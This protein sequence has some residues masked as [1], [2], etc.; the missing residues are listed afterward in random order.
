MYFSGYESGYSFD[1]IVNSGISEIYNEDQI[2]YII[3]NGDGASW[4]SAETENNIQKLYQL[5]LFH[6]YQKANRKI[7]NEESRKK[8]KKL[9]KK[10][11]YDK[12]L[13]LLKE[14]IES[15]KDVIL[16]A[17]PEGVEYRVLGTMESSIRNVIASRMKENGTA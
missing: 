3:L 2:K 14:L 4:I 6:I 16:P 1:N 7:R 5:D 8:I 15:E 12:V 11:K 13:E 17:P 9:L 10:K